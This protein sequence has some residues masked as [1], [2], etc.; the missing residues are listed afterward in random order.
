MN[1]RPETIEEVGKV[2]DVS[3]NVFSVLYFK[4][5][6]IYVIAMFIVRITK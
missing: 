3:W 6:K 2:I 1:V 4:L 5:V